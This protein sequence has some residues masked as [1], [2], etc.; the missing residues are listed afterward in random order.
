MNGICILSIVPVRNEPSDKA[1][2]V[3]QLL[4]G[5]QFKILE[6]HKSW[7]RVSL[8]YD[9]YIGWVDAKQMLTIDH[10]VKMKFTEAPSLTYDLVQIAISGTNVIP[11]VLGSTLPFYHDRKI[12]IGPIEYDYEGNVK[13]P[14]KPDI[15]N[16]TEYAAMYLNAP[17]LWGGRS[18]FGI[19]CSG[20]TQMVFKLCGI[21]LKRDTHQQIAQG[22]PVSSIETTQQGDLA[23]FRNDAGK[24]SHVGIILSLNRIIHAHGKVRIDKLDSEGIFNVDTNSY[25]HKLSHLRRME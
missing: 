13:I 2:M 15:S 6:E 4:F 8:Y 19:D 18:P 10:E 9:E 14:A 17:Y 5:E 11:I 16:L 22:K 1:E 12:H 20:F 7:R 24:V 23:F 25:S 3:T 21:Q